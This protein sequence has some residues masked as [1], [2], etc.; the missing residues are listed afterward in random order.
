MQSLYDQFNA[1]ALRI[2]KSLLPQTGFQKF[3]LLTLDYRTPI[4]VSIIYV[5]MVSYFSKLNRSQKVPS[6]KD[7]KDKE[8]GRRMSSRGK[9]ES[10]EESEASSSRFTPFKC[11]VI[12]HNIFLC[13]YSAITFLSVV[14][15]V[16][17][18]YFSG[19]IHEAVQISL[20]YLQI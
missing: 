12:A 7:K 13:L 1:S 11:L 16:L 2:S 3:H 17:K 18:P 9:K 20:T 5:L 10:S 14:P 6:T 15:L 4:V 19:S 8:G